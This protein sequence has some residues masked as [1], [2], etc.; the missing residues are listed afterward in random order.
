VRST[1]GSAAA[2]ARAVWLDQLTGAEHA[3]LDPGAP[4]APERRPD[5][6]VVG[7]GIV[8][9]ATAVACLR[10][11]LGSVFLIERQRLGAGPSGGA[12][13][14]LI[15]EAHQGTDPEPLVSLGRSSLTLWRE[16]E[17]AWP[18]GVGLIDL[19]WLGLDRFGP[20]GAS[21]G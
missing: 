18:G 14:L 12:A 2:D 5:V 6:L 4:P 3:V 17:G 9:V 16:L 8:G 21:R 11:G 7:G 10:A 15:P 13:G 20:L 1:V 19:D